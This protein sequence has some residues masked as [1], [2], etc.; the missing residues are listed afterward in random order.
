MS[1][2]HKKFERLFLFNEVAKQLS[3]T[4]AAATL[5]ISRGYLSEQ[6]RQLE[7]EFGRPLL[8]RSTRSVKLTPQGELILAKMGQVKQSLLELDRQ[9]RHDNDSIAGRIR[10]TAPSQFTQRY[11]LTICRDFQ[12]QNPLIEFTLD[13]SYTTYDLT[14][15]DFDLSIRATKTPPQNMVAKKLFSYQ[16]VC[17]AAPAYIEQHGAP[18]TIEELTQHHCLTSEEQSLW[19]IGQEPMMVKSH[20]SI[21][22]NHMLKALALDAQGIIF[23]PEYLVDRELEV[24]NLMPLLVNEPTQASSTYLVH[25][26][27]IHQSA[28]LASFITFTSDW[29]SRH[30]PPSQ[31]Q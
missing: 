29:I 13:S 18:S 3:F 9:I 21:N 11:L 17:C 24:G 5:G 20:L 22:D 27:L 28:R 6:I 1:R 15:N 12:K 2:E 7:K 23:V 25:P 26:Q 4:E 19:H 30:L 14:Q 10:I 16:Y 8:I 31:R